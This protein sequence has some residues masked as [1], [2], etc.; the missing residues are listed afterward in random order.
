MWGG[1]AVAIA[2]TFFVFAA[3]GANVTNRRSDQLVVNHFNG[4]VNGHLEAKDNGRGAL[5]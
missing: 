3:G 4:V 2:A 1:T 5:S